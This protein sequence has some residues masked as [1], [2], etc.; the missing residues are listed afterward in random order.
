MN[1]EDQSSQRLFSVRQNESMTFVVG[2]WN[3]IRKSYDLKLNL[4]AI[5][6][7]QLKA[8]LET[9]RISLPETFLSDLENDPKQNI[10]ES[11][12]YTMPDVKTGS[13]CL[14]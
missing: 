10:G 8:T 6:F 9:L 1:E 13:K 7:E 12:V 4:W 3:P 11:R 14:N 2:E 5:G